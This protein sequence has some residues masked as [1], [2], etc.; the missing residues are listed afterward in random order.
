ME[1]DIGYAIGGIVATVE[2]VVENKRFIQKFPY[3]DLQHEHCIHGIKLRWSCGDC[4]GAI[5]L[6]EIEDGDDGE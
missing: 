2:V 6:L 4:D 3:G 1:V 5:E